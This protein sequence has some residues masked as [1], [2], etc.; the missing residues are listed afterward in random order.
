MIVMD[1][2]GGI[3]F[4]DCEIVGSF[5]TFLVTI[6]C[7]YGP[8]LASWTTAD[9]MGMNDTTGRLNAYVEH[10]TFRGCTTGYVD[11][12]DNA[13][14]VDRYNEF[15]W[16]GG[17]NSHGWDTSPYGMRH[18]EIYNNRYLA[19]YNPDNLNSGTFIYP[20]DAGSGT[21][22]SNVGTNIWFRGGT[23][24]I[25]DNYFEEHGTT[26]AGGWGSPKYML[27]ASVR[28]IQDMVGG[29]VSP[30]PGGCGTVVY[31]APH[32]CGQNNDGVADF[33]DPIYAWG[34]SGT[35][36]AYFSKSDFGNGWG[37]PCG[38]PDYTVWWQS[39]RDYIW[40]GGDG[41]GSTAKPGY[42]PYTYPHP[43]A[44][45]SDTSIVL[46]GQRWV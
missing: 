28:A 13:R 14:F 31:P 34:N 36:Q 29:G 40:S 4:S 18:A 38:F 44:E 5:R 39:G 17:M 19:P 1:D 3:I 25:H 10:C 24:V 32:Q 9:S 8:G 33:T 46:A 11:C 43:L 30:F 2:P 16:C 7:L 12:D 42:T 35:F 23:G 22:S 45:E 20:F 21:Y 15:T 6:K 27:A 26:G 37:N 41:R